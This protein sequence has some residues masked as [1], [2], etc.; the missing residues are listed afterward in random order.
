[1][2]IYAALLGDPPTEEEKLQALARRLQVSRNLGIIGQM[3][4]DRVMAPVG[5][6]L[7]DAAEA[8][9]EDMGRRG[10]TARYRRYQE[11]QSRDA[12]AQDA[13]VQAWR[14][15]DA[16][17][18]RGHDFALE[19]LRQ[20]GD[21]ELERLRQKREDKATA[22]AQRALQ[23]EFDSKLAA[24][25]DDM[26]RVKMPEIMKAVEQADKEIAKYYSVDPKT[27][28]AKLKDIPGMGAGKYSPLKDA[29]NTR[30]A[31]VAPIRNILGYMRSGATI[32]PEEMDRLMEEYTG[33][34][35]W[36]SDEDFIQSYGRLKERIKAI[37]EGVY[38]GYTPEV[39]ET[40]RTGRRGGVIEM[41]E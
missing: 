20:A 35:M 26:T 16:I 11:N 9:A 34:S 5:K 37:E 14:E 33:G 15:K 6:Q 23:K 39:Q 10:E 21:L 27:G 17:A 41:D 1:M 19:R 2:D 25:G 12:L 4:G 38:R 8:Q 29:R 22:T 30:N 3:S 13:A 40:Y 7:F 32:T 18:E 28:K 24:L 36:S 31:L